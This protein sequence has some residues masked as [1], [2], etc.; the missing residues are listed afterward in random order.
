MTDDGGPK[1]CVM[2]NVTSKHTKEWE[3]M[4]G[5]WKT[6]ENWQKKQIKVCTSM[7][8]FFVLLLLSK[9]E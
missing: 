9:S 8:P 3:V 1:G 6:L 2:T 5:L 4:G 7:I